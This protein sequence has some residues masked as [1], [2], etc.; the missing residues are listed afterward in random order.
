MSLPSKFTGW[1]SPAYLAAYDTTTQVVTAANES[2]VWKFNTV[3]IAK[4]ISIVDDTKI[5]VA[6]DG[7]YNIQFSAQV[8]ESNASATNLWIWPRLNGVD[9]PQ[10]NTKYTLQGSDTADVIILNYVL[11][12]NKDDYVQITWCNSTTTSLQASLS[13]TNPNK[14]AVPSIILTVWQIN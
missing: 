7:V 9:I 4:N 6:K 2:F 1:H 8:V 12:L 13:S 14:P 5:T 11:D 10:S 3:D